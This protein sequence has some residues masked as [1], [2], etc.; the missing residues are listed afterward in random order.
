MRIRAAVPSRE[1]WEEAVRNA[2]E[3]G[4]TCPVQSTGPELCSAS[5]VQPNG[6]AI[7]IVWDP[8]HIDPARDGEV[9][10]E[11]T[12]DRAWE[13]AQAAKAFVED[14]RRRGVERLDE[15]AVRYH[16]ARLL[17][18]RTTSARVEK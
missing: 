3:D 17:K 15:E 2:N 10:G 9:D 18:R 6:D 5:F 7:R 16:L 8:L 14:M 4:W 11:A 1:A 13:A 12:F